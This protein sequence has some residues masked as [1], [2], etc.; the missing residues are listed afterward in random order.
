MPFGAPYE[1]FAR[2]VADEMG[3]NFLT[4]CNIAAGL[5]YVR[6]QACPPDHP[7][8]LAVNEKNAAK[9]RI[10]D[11]L[12]PA[13]K[14]EIGER[15]EWRCVYCQRDIS[16]RSSIDHI[17]PIEVGGTSEMSNIQLT[18]LRCNQSK[19]TLSDSDYREKLNQIERALAARETFAQESGFSSYEAEQRFY[20]CPCSLFGCPPGC[21]GCEMCEH[22]PGRPTTVTCP[23]G[24]FGMEECNE[25][26]YLQRCKLDIIEET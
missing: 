26:A 11:L 10:R 14:K 13:M 24:E 21:P 22:P 7:L 17:V 5:S 2:G 12:K 8:R 16:K 18:C 23:N 25:A 6:R 15:Q 9:Q 3:I 1:P 20:E 19:G 4:V